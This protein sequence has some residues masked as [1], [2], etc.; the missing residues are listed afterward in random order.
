M[1]DPNFTPHTA[2]AIDQDESI[3]VYNLDPTDEQDHV[4]VIYHYYAPLILVTDLEGL[5][6]ERLRAEIL[7][8]DY[9]A[10]DRYNRLTPEEKTKDRRIIEQAFTYQRRRAEQIEQ[11]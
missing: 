8:A 3:S 10:K 1:R 9:A 5:D 7:M 6:V 11:P 2:E 4:V